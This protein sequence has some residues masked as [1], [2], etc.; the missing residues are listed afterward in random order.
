MKSDFTELNSEDDIVMYNDLPEKGGYLQRNSN[1]KVGHGKEELPAR[2]T[3]PAK[4][5]GSQRETNN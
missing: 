3:E 1:T 2:I 5:T 4:K